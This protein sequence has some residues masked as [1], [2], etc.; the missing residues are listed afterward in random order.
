VWE[1]VLVKDDNRREI[2]F[3][4]PGGFYFLSGTTTLGGGRRGLAFWATLKLRLRELLG[5]SIQ[6]QG[7]KQEWGGPDFIYQRTGGGLEEQSDLQK[8]K[9][10]R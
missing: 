3:P 4:D 2:W 1:G 7:E 8:K 9:K 6:L 5:N 10:A